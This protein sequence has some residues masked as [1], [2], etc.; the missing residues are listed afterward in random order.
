MKK[1]IIIIVAI[2]AIAGLIIYL[3]TG[4]KGAQIQFEMTTVD[5]DTI[6][7][8]VTATGCEEQYILRK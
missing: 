5:L 4:K 7:N 3:A 8:S 6:Q 1:K 2:L